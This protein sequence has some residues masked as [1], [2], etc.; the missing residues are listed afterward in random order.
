[1]PD[2]IVNLRNKIDWYDM[3]KTV[4]ECACTAHEQGYKV[5]N[6]NILCHNI[7]VE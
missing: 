1:M 4:R 6:K 2:L 3:Q 5:S 7:I